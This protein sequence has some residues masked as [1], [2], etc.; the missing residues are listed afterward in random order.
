MYSGYEERQEVMKKLHE[1][2]TLFY[3]L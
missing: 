2:H 3:L 1:L